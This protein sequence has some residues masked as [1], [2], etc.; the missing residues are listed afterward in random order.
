VCRSR[1]CSN[2]VV[3]VCSYR[4]LASYESPQLQAF[5]KC[6]LQKH[7]CLENTAAIPMVPDPEPLETLLG[8]TLS[9]Q[10]AEDIFIGHLAPQAPSPQPFSWR[11]V[12]GKNPGAVSADR[13]LCVVY[14][15]NAMLPHAQLHVRC[16]KQP[17]TRCNHQRMSQG[18]C[19]SA[20]GHH[21]S[22]CAPV[23]YL[24]P[25]T[26]CVL[27]ALCV[28]QHGDGS[29]VVHACT[30]ARSLLSAIGMHALL[31]CASGSC[32]HACTLSVP[33]ECTRA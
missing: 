20:S 1:W 30:R 6:V 7:N 31:L 24:Q 32:L 25:M 11:V 23:L 15:K 14:G 4:V 17:C 29:G 2:C 16:M 28:L 10:A 21:H 8:A 33:R 9:W 3:Q 18:H 27:S 12:C 13:L 22:A 19:T 5:S 26:A